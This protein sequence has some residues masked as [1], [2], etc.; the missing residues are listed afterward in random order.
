[1]SDEQRK[2]SQRLLELLSQRGVH[3]RILEERIE[4]FDAEARAELLSRLAATEPLDLP[5]R[6]V[7]RLL[8]IDAPESREDLTTIL[9]SSLRASEPEARKAALYGLNQLAH[10]DLVAAAVAALDDSSDAVL[11]NAVEILHQV[12]EED[13]QVSERL[14]QLR[15]SLGPGAEFHCTRALLDA[16]GLTDK[17][18][19]G[20]G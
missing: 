6:V 14:Q 20:G 9:V 15:S 11:A 13:P 4:E 3:P 16:Y 18:P 2:A 1:M 8:S 17:K 7:F 10:P 5:G 19:N 12:A